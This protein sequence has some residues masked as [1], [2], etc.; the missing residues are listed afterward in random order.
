MICIREKIT[1]GEK[2]EFDILENSEFLSVYGYRS[3]RLLKVHA[4]E[5]VDK[6]NKQQP[7]LW[8]YCLK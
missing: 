6:W 1:T 7:H 4:Q 2:W 3:I 5:L 8:D